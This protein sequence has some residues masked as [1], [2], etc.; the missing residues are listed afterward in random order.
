M[1]ADGD[2]LQPEHVILPRINRSEKIGNAQ[3]PTTFLAR[4][5]E[6]KALGWLSAGRD[7]SLAFGGERLE[8]LVMVNDQIVPAGLN[9]KIAV[10][11]L[12]LEQLFI[13]GA[14][15]QVLE[16]RFGVFLQQLLKIRRRKLAMLETPL[17]TK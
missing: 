12:R 16:D 7:E 8:I 11:D 1:R 13:R 2:E 15:L 4:K 10:D 17:S 3:P 9:G 5:A 6:A 14:L